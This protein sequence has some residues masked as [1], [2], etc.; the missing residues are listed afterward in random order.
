MTES[1]ERNQPNE[2]SGKK[3]RAFCRAPGCARVLQPHLFMCGKHWR[4]VP[5]GIKRRIWRNY[6]VSKAKS[7]NPPAEWEA[8]IEEAVAA[9]DSAESPPQKEKNPPPE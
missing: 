8:L 2:T 1:K 9:I 7:K 6:S 5:V 3:R 4:M